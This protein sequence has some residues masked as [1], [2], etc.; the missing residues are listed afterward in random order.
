MDN[1]VCKIGHFLPFRGRVTYSNTRKSHQQKKKLNNIVQ[2]GSRDLDQS[3]TSLKLAHPSARPQ[4][5]SPPS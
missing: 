3:E 4:T 2:K 5:A 1:N